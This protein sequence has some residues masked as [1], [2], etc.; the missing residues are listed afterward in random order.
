MN[1]SIDDNAEGR[2]VNPVT[3]HYDGLLAAHYSWMQGATLAD[4]AAEQA[5]LLAALG[6]G[7]EPAGIAV[8]LGCGPGYQS[9]ALLTLGYERVI[10]VDTSRDLLAE[11]AAAAPGDRV[12]PVLSDLR[13]LP[14]LVERGSAGAI[15]CM[16]DTLT[17]LERHEDVLALYRDAYD[18]LKPGGRLVLTF[19]DLSRE[20]AGLERFIPVRADDTRIMTCVLDYE[21]DGVVVTDL[22]HVREDAGWVLHKSSYRKL[23]LSPATQ[24]AALQRIGFVVDHDR[25]AGRMYAISA[26]K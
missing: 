20:L 25:A 4:K 7:A 14:A 19:R 6:L 2:T 11:L 24:V 21:P 1:H 17:H 8:D 13:D 10:A 12:E 22:I 3:R 15:V 9:V 23:R 18:A 5:A 26:R 16:G